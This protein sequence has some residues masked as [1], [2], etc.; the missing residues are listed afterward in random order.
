MTGGLGRHG[1]ALVYGTA[2]LVGGV[3]AVLIGPA[4]GLDDGPDAWL[5]PLL[6]GGVGYAYGWYTARPMG[7]GNPPARP[8]D[9]AEDAPRQSEEDGADDR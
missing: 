8:A 5:T 4:L 2:G 6:S 1:P 9:D 7:G 3:V